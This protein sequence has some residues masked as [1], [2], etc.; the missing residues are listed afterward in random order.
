MAQIVIKKDFIDNKPVLRVAITDIMTDQTCVDCHNSHPERTWTSD[1]W[2]V[3]DKRGVLEV[4]TPLDEILASNLDARNNIIIF[5]S[6]IGLF[7][8]LYIS[9][10]SMKREKELL[11][12]NDELQEKLKNIL[13]DFDKNVIASTTNYE[14]YIIHAS[15]I[16]CKLSGYSK[17]ER[18]GEDKHITRQLNTTK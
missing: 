16:F 3:G 1:K 12:A 14:R 17:D 18:V 13:K 10:V 4:I 11:D 5:I 6:I 8:V 15:D 9:Y 2:K 7:L